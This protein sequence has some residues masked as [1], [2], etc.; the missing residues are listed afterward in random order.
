MG[1]LGGYR[2]SDSGLRPGGLP[3][4]GIEIRFLVFS[5]KAVKT[6]GLLDCRFMNI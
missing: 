6:A 1:E 2:A 4:G 5:I 3:G